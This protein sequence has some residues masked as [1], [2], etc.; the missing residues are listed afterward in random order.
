MGE[1]GEAGE[2]G[3][4]TLGIRSGVVIHGVS[5]MRFEDAYFTRNC[6]FIVTPRHGRRREAAMQLVNAAMPHSLCI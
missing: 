5:R 4:F 1:A 6:G 2:A 3:G